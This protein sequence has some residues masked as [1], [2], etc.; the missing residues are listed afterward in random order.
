MEKPE[1]QLCAVNT[2]VNV[3]LCWS[4]RN[5]VDWHSCSYGMRQ[6]SAIQQCGPIHTTSAMHS[7]RSAESHMQCLHALISLLQCIIWALACSSCICSCHTKLDL[8]S[9]QQR[10][11]GQLQLAAISPAGTF[12]QDACMQEQR[13]QLQIQLLSTRAFTGLSSSWRREHHSA[14]NTLCSEARIAG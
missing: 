3:T 13:A 4:G 14:L 5:F 10:L 11:S 12:Q 7:A 9:R 6:Y 2:A 8:N 1:A